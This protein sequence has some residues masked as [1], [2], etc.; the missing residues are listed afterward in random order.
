MSNFIV[1]SANIVSF[2]RP[3]DFC[4]SK[5]NVQKFVGLMLCGNCQEN[6]QITNPGMFEA[7]GQT[8][9]KAQD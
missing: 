1:D 8:E 2:P 4:E 7:N 5:E 3:C 6:I 9:Q